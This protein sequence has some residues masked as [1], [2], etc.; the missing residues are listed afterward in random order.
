ML[1]DNNSKLVEREE[2]NMTVTQTLIIILNKTFLA[3]LKL[4]V[5]N[6]LSNKYVLL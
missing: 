1:T 5:A 3:S 6:T 4:S 2:E